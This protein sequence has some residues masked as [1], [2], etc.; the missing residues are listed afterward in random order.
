MIRM[1]GDHHARTSSYFPVADRRPHPNAVHLRALAVATGAY[2]KI[3][4]AD[5]AGRASRP[6]AWVRR[7]LS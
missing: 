3:R 6:G 5:V 2:V 4:A 7:V 1:K